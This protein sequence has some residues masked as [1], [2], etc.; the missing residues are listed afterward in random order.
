M[1]SARTP[2]AS[3]STVA[4]LELRVTILATGGEA[5]VAVHASSTDSVGDLAVAGIEQLGVRSQ[6]SAPSLWCERRG[7]W[8]DGARPLTSA[9]IRWGD[10]LSLRLTD[11][12]AAAVGQQDQLSAAIEL[13][14]TSGP[15][16]GRRFGLVDGAHRLGRDAQLEIVLDDPSLSRH[17][18]DLHVE[19]NRVRVADAGS[20]NGTL[21]DGVEL[22]A[23]APRALN[24]RNE[25]E[26][27]RTLMRIQPLQRTHD[28]FEPT[29]GRIDFNRQPR[30]GAPF[31]PFEQTV[32]RPPDTP[33]KG[34]LP[35]AASALPLGAGVLLFV[36]LKSP[37]MLAIAGLSPL[38][39]ITTY[40]SDRR[41]GRRSFVRESARFRSELER[42]VIELDGA[43]GKE[44][45]QRRRSAPDAEQLLA[46]LEML[47]PTLWERRASDADFLELRVGVADLPALGRIKVEDGGE[48][49]LR[50][51]AAS[52]LSE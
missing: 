10:R 8:L 20:R 23:G 50:R 5:D 11:E 26:L 48:E 31:A 21:V 49:S 44:A 6:S 19:G 24:E 40:L 18:L 15:C 51:D 39:A 3:H 16:A 17:H 9:G 22:E 34:R 1:R 27:G 45:E 37:V 14:V 35:L 47:S 43:L 2:S 13:V 41:G 30:V 12:Q 32:K 46:R 4:R 52:T 7:E 28:D 42:A 33:R 38:M 29:A 36:L 25:L